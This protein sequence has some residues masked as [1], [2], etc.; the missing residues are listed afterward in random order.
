MSWH[1][2]IEIHRI[3]HRLVPRW[4]EMQAVAAV[5]GQEIDGG[6]RI[7]DSGI[8]IDITVEG[9]IVADPAVDRLPS[10]LTGL[11]STDVPQVLR[12]CR[13]KRP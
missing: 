5:G 11:P 12:S 6:G 1:E 13:K 7:P 9:G 2:K 10:G 4:I 8:E 3:G